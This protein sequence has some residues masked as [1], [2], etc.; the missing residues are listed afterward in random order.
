MHLD[1][2]NA[3]WLGVLAGIARWLDVPAA[4]VRVVFVICVLAWPPFV[5]GYFLLYLCLDKELTPDKMR[6]YFRSS[7]TA[8]HFRKLDYRKP[9]YRNERNKR[10][11]GVCAGIADYFEVSAFSVR[12]VTLL[13]LFVF[14]PFTF[15]AYIVCWIVFDPDPLL[16]DNSRYQRRME[17]RRRR[18]SRRQRRAEKRATREAARDAHQQTADPIDQTPWDEDPDYDPTAEFFES[19]Q[20]GYSKSESTRVFSDLEQRLREIEAYMTSKRFRLHCQINRI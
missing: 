18:Q 3:R 9:I 10:I 17:R 14:G 16:D 8:E 12:L 7:T 20:D 13:S 5:L 2:E 11:A 6:D 15:W 1:R 4:L 19:E